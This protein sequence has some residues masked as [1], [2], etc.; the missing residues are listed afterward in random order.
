MA[1]R[2]YA[3]GLA[4]FTADT[5]CDTRKRLE[6]AVRSLSCWK[7]R[8]FSWSS[9]KRQHQF[10]STE[11]GMFIRASEPRVSKP[12]KGAIG[13]PATEHHAMRTNSRVSSLVSQLAR[14]R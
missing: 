8:V 4:I 10:A 5:V 2:P 11:P 14:F 12:C 6:D 1:L 7:T 13:S 9:V 3:A